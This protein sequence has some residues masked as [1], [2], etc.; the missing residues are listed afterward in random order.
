MKLS[1]KQI[2]FPLSGAYGMLILSIY[3]D[4]V[5]I[6]FPKIV[7]KLPPILLMK[8]LLSAIALSVLMFVV[9]LFIYLH[10]KIK[11]VSK[12]GVLWDKNKEPYCPVHRIPFARHKTKIGDSPGT[13]FN[14]AKCPPNHPYPLITDEC[15]RL[16]IIEAKKL[17]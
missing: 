4:L 5:P 7:Q 14:C 15:K 9:S 3:Y 13:G 1:I 10:L 16:T 6:I 17:L 11:L 2:L 12:F 8:F